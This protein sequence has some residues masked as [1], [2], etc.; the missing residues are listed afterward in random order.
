MC[1]RVTC[2]A[3][4]LSFKHWRISQVELEHGT[5][6]TNRN[7][8]TAGASS[9]TNAYQK[10]QQIQGNKLVHDSMRQ[11]LIGQR[12]RNGYWN[13]GNR[14]VATLSDISKKKRTVSIQSGMLDDFQGQL[15]NKEEYT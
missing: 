2:S 3:T 8:I 11:I 1:N 15:S 4:V 7:P 13:I 5:V 14:L 6:D 10:K 9:S 12:V